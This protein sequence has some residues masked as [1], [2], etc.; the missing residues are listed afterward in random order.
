MLDFLRGVSS[1]ERGPHRICHGASPSIVPPHLAGVLWQVSGWTTEYCKAECNL[2]HWTLGGGVY[3]AWASLT[4]NNAPFRA[5]G[6]ELRAF[7][8]TAGLLLAWLLIGLSCPSESRCNVNSVP[9]W[10]RMSFS[11]PTTRPLELTGSI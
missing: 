7:E 1:S 11:I 9:G 10:F 4:P 6:S 3:G 5:Q 2:K 8:H